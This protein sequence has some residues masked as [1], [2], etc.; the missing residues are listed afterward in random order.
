MSVPPKHETHLECAGSY[1]SWACTCGKTSRHLL[2]LYKA[3]RNAKAHERGE[4][5]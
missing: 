5:P 1:Y 2:P 4:K 3:Q